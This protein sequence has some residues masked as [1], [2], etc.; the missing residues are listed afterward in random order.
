MFMNPADLAVLFAVIIA[1]VTYK[2]FDKIKSFLSFDDSS[3]TIHSSSRD[4]AA[5]LE[6]N[7]KNYLVL[8]G[9]QTGTTE[10]YARKFS[11]ELAAKFGLN[12]MCVDVENYDFDTLNELP[13]NVLVS[14]FFSTYGE[15]DFP[16][17]AV[18]FEEF[19]NSASDDTLNNVKFTLFGFGNSTYEFF[20]G[21]AEKA[22]KGLT[23]AGATLIGRMGEADDGKDST[24]EDYLTWKE[25][26]FDELKNYLNLDEQDSGFKASFEL[27]KLNS[28]DNGTSLGEPSIKYLPANKLSYNSDGQ[29]MGP[30]DPSHPYISPI[31]KSH[32][33]FKSLDRNCI[34]TEFDISDSDMTYTTG[35]HLAIWPSNAVEKVDQFLS[36]FNLLPDT[37]FNLKPHDSTID[38]P[39]PCPTTIGAAVKHYIEITGPI[40]RQSFSLLAEFAPKE[41][42][43]YVAKLAK[44]KD[45]FHKEITSKNFNLADALYYLSQGK[46]WTEVPWEFLLETIPHLQ[47]RYY[48]ISSS[49]K[50]EPTVVHVTSIVENTS[51]PLTGS[52]T[53]GVTTNLLRNIQ[54]AKSSQNTKLLPVT[55]DLNGPRNLFADYKLPIHVR[56]SAFKLP[57]DLSVPVIMIGPGT[58]VAP[59]R[60]FVRERVHLMESGQPTS[61]KMMLFYGSRDET[62]FL[63]ENEWPEYSQKLDGSFEMVVAFSRTQKEKIYVQHKMQE[64]KKDIYD[65][66]DKGAHVYVCGDAS[67]MAKDVQKTI[68]EILVEFRNVSEPTASE[69]IKNMK[70]AGKYQEDVW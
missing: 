30:F 61:G 7:D 3:V 22:L 37:V 56:H 1:V 40:S 41:I 15:G 70:L 25:E 53:V 10:D 9:S 57:N 31:V 39:F 2:C 54:M 43:E 23:A 16:D 55:Y 29:Q 38:L 65:L 49:S 59:F 6:E 58:G 48:S 44:D 62:D 69:I 4:I 67:R 20:N 45:A 5:V 60:G 32:E 51:N 19:L 26:I 21:A 68:A 11:K 36:V 18:N 63:Y 66:L 33:L 13:D 46:P 34:H 17:G 52:P 24:D 64:R 8:Y 35:D 50:S 28:V 47:P 12:V 14:L 27:T 42:K